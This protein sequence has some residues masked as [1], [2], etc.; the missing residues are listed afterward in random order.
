MLARTLRGRTVLSADSDGHH[1]PEVGL[2]HFDRAGQPVPAR[3]Q[4]HRSQPVQHLPGR[5]V[6]ADLEEPLKAEHRNAVRL[7]SEHPADGGRRRNV[8][9][10]YGQRPTEFN[11][12]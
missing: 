3:P 6:R 11:G 7:G 12:L 4:L 1:V 8:S 9:T 2:L 10:Y 5:R